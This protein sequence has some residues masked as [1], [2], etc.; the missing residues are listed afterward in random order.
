MKTMPAA[1][2]H[3]HPRFV[4]GKVQPHLFGSFIEHLGR[5]V[6]GGIYEPGHPH[7]DENGFRQD[8]LNLVKN[9]GVSMVR[10]PG[11]NFVSGYRWEDGVGPR[12]DRPRRL[13]PAWRTIETNEFGTNE[14]IS[15]CRGASVEPMIAVNL[16]TR[17]MEEARALLEYCNVPEGTYW[18]DLRRSHGHPRPHAV[19]YWC[20]GN[21]M[22]GPWQMGHKKAHEYGRLACESGRLMKMIDPGIKL[23]VC[24][25]SYPDIPSFPQWDATVLEETYDIADFI[26][27]H[28]YLGKG[29]YSAREKKWMTRSW[30]NYM[31]TPTIMERQIQTVIQTADYVRA[32]LRSPKRIQLSFDEWNIWYQNMDP[33]PD[34]QH[35]E[36]WSIAPNQLED[37]YTFEDA[38]VFGGMLLNL[39]RHA[40]RV[41]LACLA[42]LVNVIAPIM[43]R[44]G[45]K[46]WPQTIFWPFLHGSLYG[47]GDS[48]KLAVECPLMDAG[49][50]GEVPVLDVAATQD[51]NALTLFVINRQR[52]HTQP[53]HLDLSVF[54]GKCQVVEHIVMACS[55]I[56]AR[57]TERNPNRVKPHLKGGAAIRNRQLTAT[58]APASWNVI[59]IRT[60]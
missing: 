3:L 47:R 32:K 53:L 35:H 45:G 40:D 12:K 5:A 41:H 4:A 34:C 9:L 27:L 8:V 16:G 18:S 60:Q 39:L 50:L 37:V 38:L 42:Q 1:R 54:G 49:D 36:D 46:A 31:A 57:N 59:R 48:L 11:G 2:L 20:L 24:G 51:D 58:L 56:E 22:D 55:R 23:V 52:K 7:A 28:L 19:R 10:Y 26:S 17:G 44:T 43:T 33:N 14:F 6:Y 21:E 30:E 29:Y 25:S 15:W 13:D